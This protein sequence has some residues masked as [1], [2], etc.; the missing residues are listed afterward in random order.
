[1]G[2]GGSCLLEY[3]LG[4]RQKKERKGRNHHP[5]PNAPAAPQGAAGRFIWG[6]YSIMVSRGEVG[7]R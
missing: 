2:S 4:A 6:T 3:R 5:K 7:E 1:M